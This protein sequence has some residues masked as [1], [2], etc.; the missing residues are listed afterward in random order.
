MGIE[1]LTYEGRIRAV[2]EDVLERYCDGALN[3][4]ARAHFVEWSA[5]GSANP[6]KCADEIVEAVINFIRT[7]AKS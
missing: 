1:E 6:Q 7:E 5:D 4:L 2:V 3:G